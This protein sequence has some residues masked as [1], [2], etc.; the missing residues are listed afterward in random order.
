MIHPKGRLLAG[1]QHLHVAGNAVRMVYVPD[2]LDPGRLTSLK[3]KSHLPVFDQ[4]AGLAVLLFLEQS[5]GVFIV[6]EGYGGKLGFTKRGRTIISIRSDRTG[7]GALTG[8][9]ALRASM[10]MAMPTAH[11]TRIRT[12]KCRGLPLFIIPV[13]S[14]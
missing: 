5:L 11:N 1:R 7:P 13:P 3:S 10:P 4:M 8:S 6:R 2:L 14:R 9:L 12:Q